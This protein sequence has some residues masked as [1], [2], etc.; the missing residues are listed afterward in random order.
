MHALGASAQPVFALSNGEVSR[1]DL[2]GADALVEGWDLIWGD[3]RVPMTPAYWAA[4]AWMWKL[5]EPEHFRLG[6]TLEEELLACL[7]GGHGIPAEVGLAAYGRLREMMNASP[8]ALTDFDR[9]M[10]ALSEPLSV[11][12]RAVRYRFARQKAAYVAAAFQELPAIDRNLGDEAH[13]D[14]LVSLRGVGPKTASWVVRNLKRSDQV[15]IL[16]VHILRAGRHLGIFDPAHVVERHY[17]L[18]E[19][20]YLRFA[21]AIATPASILDSVMWMT[22]RQLPSVSPRTAVRATGTRSSRQL[23]LAL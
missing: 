23:A 17:S 12:G 18:L 9:V 16:D 10:S 3:A 13:R 6:E 21:Q 19:A 8:N 20:A 7:L 1:L 15:A 4:Q 11:N 5:D 14:R 2:P 22:M